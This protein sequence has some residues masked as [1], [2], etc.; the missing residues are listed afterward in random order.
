MQN[1]NSTPILDSGSF[2]FERGSVGYTTLWDLLAG[3]VYHETFSSLGGGSALYGSGKAENG[4]LT[5]TVSDGAHSLVFTNYAGVNALVQGTR[6]R[7]GYMD[8]NRS[9]TRLCEDILALCRTYGL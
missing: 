3:E 4:Y 7:I 6:C 2:S 9:S 5:I 8:G 1:G